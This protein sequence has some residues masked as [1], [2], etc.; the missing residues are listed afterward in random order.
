MRR[1][2]AIVLTGW[3]ASAAVHAAEL[4]VPDPANPAAATLP[5]DAAIPPSNARP[6]LFV[7]GHNGLSA[8][9]ADFNYR[10]NWI[11][12]LGAL[13]SFAQTLA[14]SRNAALGIEAYFIRFVDQT[15]SITEDAA[16]LHDAVGQILA[17]HDPAYDPA[18]P[19]ADTEVQVAIVA[20]SKGT[21][22]SRLYLKS[23]VEQVEG[24]PAP[25]PQLRPVSEFVAIAPPNHG[26]STLLSAIGDALS[27]DQLNNGYG[28][29]FDSAFSDSVRCL[30]TGPDAARD[31]IAT[32]NGHPMEDTHADAVPLGSYPSEAPDSRA[33][34]AAPGEG[35]LYVTLY[36]S[37][38][39][40]FV[41]GDDPPGSEANT[42]Y[43]EPDCDGIGLIGSPQPPKQGRVLAR[44]LAPDAVNV[45]VASITG[46]DATTVHQRTVHTGEVICTALHT[47]VHRGVPTQN[48][49]AV[50]EGDIPEVVPTERVA[51]EMVLDF[52]GSMAHPVCDACQSKA[53]ILHEAAQLFVDLWALVASP[54]DHLGVTYFRTDVSEM[55]CADAPQC[56]SVAAGTV[57]GDQ[58]LVPLFDNAARIR[59]NVAEQNPDGT[60]AMG[61][62]LANALTRLSAF[63]GPRKRVL[64]F[65]DGMQNR[66]PLVEH[67][68]EGCAPADC[69]YRI[70][71]G[72]MLDDALGIAIDTIGVGAGDPYLS[73]LDGIATATGGVP[74]VTLDPDQDL[75]QFFVEDVIDVLRGFSPQ[76]V[77]YRRGRLGPDGSS[78]TFVV[79]ASAEKIVL[80]LSGRGTRL[81]VFKG[82]V[83]LTALG[84]R[85]ERP[86]YRL[87]TLDLPAVLEGV[88]MDSNGP[89]QVRLEGREGGAYE[90]AALVDEPLLEFDVSVGAGAHV[91]GKP[92]SLTAR[93]RV[94]GQPLAAP[95][96]LSVRAFVPGASLGN[97]LATTPGPAATVA[98]DREPGATAG[99]RRLAALLRDP[100][101]RAR[102]KPQVQ[103]LPMTSTAS[104]VYTT[105]TARLTVPGPYRFE[106]QLTGEHPKVGSI[107]RLST[108]TTHVEFAAADVVTTEL[109]LVPMPDPDGDDRVAL[110]LRPRDALGNF[111]GPDYGQRLRVAVGGKPAAGIEDLGDGTYRI[112]L[113]GPVESDTPLAV[114]VLGQTVFAGPAGDLDATYLAPSR[115]WW[116]YL[117]ALALIVLVVWLVRRL[118]P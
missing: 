34:G 2:V 92:V 44:N 64:L 63:D 87:W 81:R 107:H 77:G 9:D 49:C 111:L 11:D 89:W 25:R 91:V 41:G 68:P 26:L 52:S 8:N 112:D 55:Q 57:P 20:Y 102:L 38:N 61:G 30:E 45:A 96:D 101:V 4:Y 94:G 53:A 40:D 17:R 43:T 35:V 39:R 42:Q 75:R 79:N 83:D 46:G 100:A 54:G 67:V 32:L 69:G 7:H 33:P 5:F 116:Q 93:V 109:T 19:D 6:V 80:T 104:G 10:K 58:A 105:S 14:D 95:V 23:L 72:A 3:L 48:E 18:D 31:F 29:P 70:A 110:R 103:S 16:E 66:A 13:P 1:A 36:A 99:Q 15:R 71:G 114:T 118:A 51:V 117:A 108:I 56:V 86:A 28:P 88:R 82:G 98:V 84:R 22:S 47:V 12:S 106:F 113:G 27:G 90:L 62:A 74:R 50:A 60:T 59:A 76:L 21:L 78:E 115:P 97:L 24:L 37:G 73:L 85:V 65:T